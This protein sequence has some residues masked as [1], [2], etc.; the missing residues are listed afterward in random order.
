MTRALAY[1][2]FV[3]NVCFSCLAF[4]QTSNF[5]QVPVYS[6][7]PVI[8]DVSAEDSINLGSKLEYF[9][10]PQ[11][12][13]S[14]ADVR[15][16]EKHDWIT[17]E[18]DTPNFGYTNSSYWFRFRL[19]N[20]VPCCGGL[21][22]NKV[23]AI[24]YA[25][26]DHIE[27][28]EIQDGNIM[29]SD[30]T[31]DIYPFSQRPL[32]HRDFLFPI[33]LKFNE[34]VDIYF[35]VSTQG[36]TQFPI[37]IWNAQ[38]FTFADQD[39][40]VVKAL[41]YGMII[42]LVLYNLF[43]FI[44][45]RERPYI[46]YVGM[47]ASALMLMSGLHGFLFQ[48]VFPQSPVFHK[49]NILISVPSGL[50]FAALFSSYFLRLDKIAP[51]L[52]I[53]MNI[54]AVIFLACIAGAFILP[55]DISTRISVFLAVPACLIIMFSG[56]YAWSK[57]QTAARYF[58]IAWVF[59]ML[60]AIISALSKFGVFPSNSFTENA[61]NWGSAIESIL[62]SF[63]LADRFNTERY[64]K[65]K[66]QRKQL[67]E[68]EQRKTAETKLY[69]QATHQSV[70]GFPN[71]VMLQ[72]LLHKLL[73]SESQSLRHFS[74]V[75]IHLSR[76]QEINKTL[77]HANADIVLSIFSR[78]LSNLTMDEN[79]SLM[80]E[81]LDDKTHYFAHIEGVI[82][83][84]IL[85]SG[86]L[87]AA[88]KAVG[89]IRKE[90]AA[91][92]E[93]NGMELD[94]GLSIGIASYPTHG[95]DIETII[96]HARVAIDGA[97]SLNDQIGVYSHDVNPYSARRL[98]LM[99]ELKKAIDTN[100]LALHYQPIICCETGG[101]LGAEALLRWNHPTLGF[102]PP[103]EFVLVAE[104]T[105]IIRSLTYWVLD[106]AL[107]A[108]ATWPHV[109]QRKTISV[110]ISAVNLHEKDF[111]SNLSAL[112]K[113][114][115]V[116]PEDLV[117]ELTET[118]VMTDPENAMSVLKK[119]ADDGV[120]IGIDDFG[121]GHSSM[122]YIQQLPVYEIKIDR[123][124]VMQMDQVSGDEVIVRT[125]LNLSHDLGYKVVAEGVENQNALDKLALMGCDLAQGYHIARPM[126]LD[127]LI[128]WI[129]TR[130]DGKR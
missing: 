48:Y 17:S 112:L 36:S 90:L 92:I 122:S 24:E 41:Y 78:K 70:D 57:G 45:I 130:G 73:H 91:P 33:S 20:K 42:A 64:A 77:G 22:E 28:Y 19:N 37:S 30:V 50:L 101:M 93:F 75:F 47:M 125:T 16:I 52:N 21:T 114:H 89:G 110:N 120:K 69:Y 81:R 109:G 106:N 59:L 7:V 38:E 103:D 107:A 40:Q 95:T 117:L 118:S 3:L 123:S 116:R 65:F 127:A 72:Q 43:L 26:L 2:I 63:A 113:K 6:S 88:L 105:G 87:N 56:P 25:L 124:F 49:M 18:S 61:V 97:N 53:V 121:T 31:G 111:E 58:T 60:G 46:Y 5:S 55:Y 66:A 34:P 9:E 67:E 100:E 83:A 108:H 4:G 96:R 85:K 39:E 74:L 80:I 129:E 71:I 54:L 11:N 98:V 115:D 94:L 35:R 79:V 84:H 27:Y 128:E 68:A 126:P 62:L 104:K 12:E 29:K 51:R 10:D 76:I 15:R 13:L 102:V 82:F 44:S 99:G 32:R 23:I 14:L 1:F 119:L 8:I 86:E